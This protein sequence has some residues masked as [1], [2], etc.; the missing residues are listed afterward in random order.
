VHLPPGCASSSVRHLSHQVHAI[1][2][3]FEDDVMDCA[4]ATS[5][6]SRTL[7]RSIFRAS[8]L[9]QRCISCCAVHAAS[10]LAASLP[11]GPLRHVHEQWPGW[12]L[13]LPAAA[14]KSQPA[15]IREQHPH[16]HWRCA[17]PRPIRLRRRW[18]LQCGDS[19]G[20]ECCSLAFFVCSA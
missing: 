14:S 12:Q 11:G 19:S 13:L 8:S 17:R 16:E 20:S 6:H 10:A 2:I 3:P 5:W 4:P 7:G 15:H 9:L 18:T 1:D